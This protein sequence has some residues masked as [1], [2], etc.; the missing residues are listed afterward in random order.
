MPT[1]VLIADDHSLI[2]RG[3]RQL[4]EATGEY[5]ITEASSGDEALAYILNQKPE[6]AILDI[7]MPVLTGVQ[8]AGKIGEEKVN[9]KLI[10]LTMHKDQQ[11]FDKAIELDVKGYVLKENT[12]TEITECLT[13]VIRGGHYIS[14]SMSN[15]L[16]KSIQERSAQKESSKRL[17]QLTR[18]ELHVLKEVSQL[19]T[20]AEIA[21]SLKISI[22]TVQNHRANICSKLKINGAHALLKFAVEHKDKMI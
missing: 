11:V 19:R 1:N 16:I 20:N 5:Q 8:I 21:E 3:L 15:Y 4:L 6:I 12:V 2:R 18:S 13:C 14:P 7:D 17:E 22:K 9:T 10:F